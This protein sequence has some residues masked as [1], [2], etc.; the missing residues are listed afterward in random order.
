MDMGV[1]RYDKLGVVRGGSGT[2]ETSS[3]KIAIS[4][5]DVVFLPAGRSHRFV[6][7]PAHPMTLMMVCFYPKAFE[8]VA[9]G[10]DAYADFVAE[11]PAFR[12][13][14]PRLSHRNFGIVSAL[15]LMLFEQSRRR[16][17]S[18][19]VIWCETLELLVMLARSRRDV[20]EENP[21]PGGKLFARTLSY[22]ED[23]FIHAVTVQDLADM[24]GLSY[25][26]YTDVFKAHTGRTVNR[27]LTD[28]RFNYAV[29]RLLETGNIQY[30]SL[31]AGFGDLAH[32]YRVFK[33]RTGTTPRRYLAQA[34][35][36]A[37]NNR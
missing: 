30:A 26:R 3:E 7:D 24:A 17:G 35:T 37:R 14:D 4:E 20:R 10:S 12:P 27:Y 18:D 13:F 32:F 28:L 36:Q 21:A 11:F 31:D 9:A 6:D 29:D 8:G 19:A 33:A 22:L 25:R 16:Q 2:V 23:N 1:W 5:N 15:K 34:Q